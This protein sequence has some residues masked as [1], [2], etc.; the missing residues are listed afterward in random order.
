VT[1]GKHNLAYVAIAA[2]VVLGIA[3]RLAHH[4]DVTDRSPDEQVYTKP[5]RCDSS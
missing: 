2:A 4:N 5:E 3:L 1:V